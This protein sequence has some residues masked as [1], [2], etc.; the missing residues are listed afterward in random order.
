MIV[1]EQQ[2]TCITPPRNLEITST[3]LWYN[4]P[5]MSYYDQTT[6]RPHGTTDYRGPGTNLP[7]KLTN[8]R[9]PGLYDIQNYFSYAISTPGKF[10]K[11]SEHC[12][13]WEISIIV[14]H[15]LT[16]EVLPI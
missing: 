10:E 4:N 2:I 11:C 16:S 6:G 13:V 8:G 12:D 1:S 3:Y 14:N 15:G 9:F 7:V 5:G